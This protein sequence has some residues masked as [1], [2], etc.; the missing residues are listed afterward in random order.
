MA[1]TIEAFVLFFFSGR[2]ESPKRPADV[3]C[4]GINIDCDSL[5]GT[6]QTKEKRERERENPKIVDSRQAVD[7][8]QI[9]E[10]YGCSLRI[11]IDVV[12]AAFFH[13]AGTVISPICQ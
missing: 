6:T 2:K 4:R 10:F 3:S 8:G 1:L 11:S 7:S 9:V 13:A 12:F 5:Q